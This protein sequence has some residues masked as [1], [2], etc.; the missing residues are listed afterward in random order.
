MRPWEAFNLKEPVSTNPDE[1]KD[2]GLEIGTNPKRKTS[3]KM[4][5]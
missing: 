2:V 1:C 5:I 4:K 3:V